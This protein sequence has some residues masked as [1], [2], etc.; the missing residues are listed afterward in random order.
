M[1]GTIY[2]NWLPRGTQMKKG[3]GNAGIEEQAL[4]G[5]GSQSRTVVRQGY[6]GEMAAFHN[7]L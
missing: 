5:N 4:E 7:L 3:F 2:G 6:K 1:K